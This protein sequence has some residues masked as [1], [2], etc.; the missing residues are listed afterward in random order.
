MRSLARE[1]SSSRRAPPNAASKSPAWSASSSDF[2]FSAPQ[3]A[4]VPTRNGCVPSA[5][6]SVLVWTISRAPDLGRI[7][8]AELDHLAELVGGVDVQQR[9]RNRAR[10]ER[11]LREPQHHRG[12]LA[13]GVE[14]HRPLEFGDHLAQD[15]DALGLERAQMIEPV[16]APARLRAPAYPELNSTWQ[17]L[18]WSCE[19]K[20][21]PGRVPG[22]SIS[23]LLDSKFSECRLLQ[24]DPRARGP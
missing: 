10:I 11:L 22:L 4:L 12:V 3:H 20:K 7:A 18:T 15:V 8:I 23:V 5:I 1:R 13:D 6:A 16:A 21:S 9:E 2:V 17:L 19:Q 14:H 24:Q